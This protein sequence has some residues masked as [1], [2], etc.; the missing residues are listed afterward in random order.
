[1]AVDGARIS[2]DGSSFIPI[3]LKAEDPERPEG[4]ERSVFFDVL[5][6]EVPVQVGQQVRLTLFDN[7]I[8]EVEVLE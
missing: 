6:G 5:K 1:M 8:K 3:Q 7:I 2:R 4:Y